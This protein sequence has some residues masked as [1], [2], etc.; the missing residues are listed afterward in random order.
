MFSLMITHREKQVSKLVYEGFTNKEIAEKASI[1]VRTVEVQRSNTMK[2]MQ[3]ES[4]AELITK[5]ND[6]ENLLT[7]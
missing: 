5:L 6:I 3:T 1:S 4:L 2:K 7:E